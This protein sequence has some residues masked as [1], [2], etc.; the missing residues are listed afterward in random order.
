[1]IF[2]TATV[3]QVEVTTRTAAQAWH[4]K[5]IQTATAHQAEA[6]IW[7]AAQTLQAARGKAGVL[8]TTPPRVDATA[9]HTKT[10]HLVGIGETIAG[11]DASVIIK[12]L[13]SNNQTGDT[14]WIV[15]PRGLD[16]IS[17]NPHFPL[18]S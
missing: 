11:M 3:H 16:T 17:S 6:T 9:R 18:A 8:T 12:R 7:T 4:G 14:V 13:R 10:A 2:Q 15:T 1:M 5:I